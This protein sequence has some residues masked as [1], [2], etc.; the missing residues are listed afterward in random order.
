MQYSLITIPKNSIDHI[1]KIMKTN[2]NLLQHLQNW[3]GG[4]SN[5]V[6]RRVRTMHTAESEPSH[7]NN[8]CKLCQNHV[9]EVLLK[10]AKKEILGPSHWK[11]LFEEELLNEKEDEQIPEMC[12]PDLI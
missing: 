5:D 2:K 8:T 4:F 9:E 1:H 7:F 10:E 3:I 6:E 12:Q 11:E